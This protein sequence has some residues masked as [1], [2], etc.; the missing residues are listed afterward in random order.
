MIFLPASQV[1]Q[2]VVKNPPANAG[3]AGDSWATVH[4]VAESELTKR[5]HA[6]TFP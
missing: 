5:P 2:S 4:G 6:H 3:D 1:A